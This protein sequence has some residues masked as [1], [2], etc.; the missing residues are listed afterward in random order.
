MKCL[1]QTL[2]LELYVFMITGVIESFPLLILQVY[3]YFFLLMVCQ[4]FYSVFSFPW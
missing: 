2:L 3:R 4:T 1:L